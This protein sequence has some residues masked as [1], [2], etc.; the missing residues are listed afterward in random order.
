ML[1]YGAGLWFGV[2]TR[3]RRPLQLTG[4]SPIDASLFS[5]EDHGCSSQVRVEGWRLDEGPGH[6]MDAVLLIATSLPDP[7]ALQGHLVGWIDVE[8]SL[9]V[10]WPVVSRVVTRLEPSARLWR[11]ARRVNGGSPGSRT[12]PTIR[13]SE[14]SKLRGLV[15]HA[16]EAIGMELDASQPQVRAIAI[17]G[18]GVGLE[19]SLATGIGRLVVQ[20]RGAAEAPAAAVA[21]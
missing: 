10:R 11:L 18:A 9:G 6:S 4:R 16:A 13:E 1:N 7:C 14:W 2:G 20:A 17:P 21:S 8:A 3:S 5:Y 19:A 12:G 15:K